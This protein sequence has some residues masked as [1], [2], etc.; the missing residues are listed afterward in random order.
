[1]ET[2]ELNKLKSQWMGLDAES[3]SSIFNT[4][5]KKED[6]ECDSTSGTVLWLG[7][8]QTPTSSVEQNLERKINEMYKL[9]ITYFRQELDL[10]R[11]RLEQYQTNAR[12]QTKEL[13]V[14]RRELNLQKL[15][16]IA[17]YED[18]W[19]GLGTFKF[20][21]KIISNTRVLLLSTGLNRQPKIFP[22]NNNSIQLEYEK[23]N[24]YLEIEVF[25]DK[26]QLFAE[27]NGEESESE[28]YSIDEVISVMNDF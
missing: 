16:R 27:R 23:K 28:L 11:N 13:N 9:L 1:M 24:L 19:N 4:G 17:K 15:D 10:F 6:I 22:T 25:T 7:E 5:A 12:I 20:D 26:Y 8:F 21:E 14:V 2:F 18:N 3:L